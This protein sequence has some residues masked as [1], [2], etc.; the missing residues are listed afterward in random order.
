MKLFDENG[1]DI[2]LA[3]A[4]P[5]RKEIL[6][7]LFHKFRVV[8]SSVPEDGFDLDPAE[9]TIEL[10]SRKAVQV[11]E[12]NPSSLVIGADTVVV[13]DGNIMGKPG[14]HDLAVEMLQQLSGRSHTVITG[15]SCFS[16]LFNFSFY[17]T[18][19]VAFR[20]MNAE[21]IHWY[22]NTNEAFEKAGAYAIQGHA[23]MFIERI[24]GNYLNVVGFPLSSFYNRL[25]KMWGN[26]SQS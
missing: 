11:F 22:I 26:F 23:S 24:N 9:L 8:P 15:V 4:S 6:S 17:E 21:E 7:L 3:S 12:K 20:K 13:C 19:E 18:T 25:K 1:V 5:R 14:S 10:A 2:V 16:S